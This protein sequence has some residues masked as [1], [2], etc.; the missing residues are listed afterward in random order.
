M[1]PLVLETAADRKEKSSAEK[2]IDGTASWLPSLPWE[3]GWQLLALLFCAQHVT[4]G[5]VNGF[6]GAALQYVF[7]SY[8]VSAPRIGVLS[9]VIALPWALKPAIGVLSDTCPFFGFSKMPYMVISTSAGVGAL[10]ILGLFQSDLSLDT[11]VCLLFIVSLYM[12]CVDLLSEAVYAR[13][14][15]TKPASGPTLLSYVWGGITIAGIVA[16]LLSG[17]ILTIND[18]SPWEIFNVAVLPASLVLMPAAMNWM[19]EPRL[20]DAQVQVQREHI[21]Q[22]RESVVLAFVML[23]ATLI[24]VFSGMCLSTV[25]NAYMSFFVS[26][27]VLF[28][29]SVSLHPTIAKVNAFTLIQGCMSVS[30]QGAS[31]YFMVDNVDQYPEGPHFSTSFYN[32]VLPLVGSIMSLVGIWFYNHCAG[33]WTYQKMY[34][35]GNLVGCVCSLFDVVFFM[36]ANRW[37][38]LDDHFFVIGS[39]SIQSVLSQWLWMP[40]VVLLSQLCP[41]GMEAIMYA[42]LAGCANLGSTIAGSFGALLLQN[43]GVAPNGSIGESAQF[44]N[45]W[46][47]A[48]VASVLPLIPVITVPWFIPDKLNTEPIFER[49]VRVNEGSLLRRYYGLDEHV[50]GSE[51]DEEL[52]A[53]SFKIGQDHQELI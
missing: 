1:E 23:V 4:K 10:A 6:T 19:K 43:L 50:E 15:R 48:L 17:F 51:R 11:V 2:L 18:G 49:E 45:L 27:A 52:S 39:S 7:Q 22:Q 46:V 29:F 26:A 38:G 16:T 40:S 12:S 33:T 32:V 35:I 42:N 9:A 41:K 31:F 14:L 24:L 53:A 30:I 13:E 44:N 3:F 21:Y 47:A 37:I 28:A 25:S 34:M 5:F 20:S 36:R 8:S